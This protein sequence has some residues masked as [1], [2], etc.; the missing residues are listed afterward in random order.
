MNQLK[1]GTKVEME[2][3]GLAKKL[4]SF[5]K[6]HHHLPSD[7]EVAKLIAQAHIKEDKN[8]YTKLKKARL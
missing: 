5:E 3:K 1:Q 7:K 6:K 8:Y 2:H 4:E